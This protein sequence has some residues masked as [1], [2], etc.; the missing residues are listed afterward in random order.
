M[1]KATILLML[2]G[3]FVTGQSQLYA[4]SSGTVR[5]TVTEASSGEALIG[6]NITVLG[7]TRGTVSDVDGRYSISLAPGSYTLRASFVSYTSQTLTV[8]VTA[9]QTTDLNFQLESDIIGSDELI[10]LGTRS[11]Q[12]TVI[13]SAVPVDVITNLEIEQFAFPQTT[14]IIR[15]L[16]PSFN[17][18]KSSVTDG[19]DHI[20][21][22]TLRGLGPDQVLVLVNGKR[23]HTSSLVHVNGSIGRGSTGVDLNAIPSNM[24]ERIEVLRDGAAAQY[25]S[26]AIAGVINI[27]L[28]KTAGLDASLTLGQN[29]SVENRGYEKEESLAPGTNPQSWAGNSQFLE[30][31]VLYTDGQTM[32]F[33]LGYGGEL[34]DRGSY[35]ISGQY[36]NQEPNNR[37]GNDPRQQYPLVNGSPDPREATFNRVNHK[38]GSAELQDLSLFLNA[39]YQMD[40]QKS[41]YA[42]GGVSNR[43]G[44][45]SGFYRRALDARNTLAIYPDGFLPHIETNIFD[46]SLSTG[47]KGQLGDWDYDVSQTLG[48]NRLEYGVNKSL[49]AS[50]GETSPSKFYAGALQFSQ[51]S[52]NL[53]MVRGVDVGTA[54]PLSVAFG[55]E[56]RYEN[57]EIEAGEAPSYMAGPI[58]GKAAGSQVFPGFQPR[59]A[60]DKSRTNI[61]L[62]LDLENDITDKFLLG[63]AVRYENYSDFGSVLTAKAST[64]FE[65]TEE[66]AVRGAVSTGFRAPSLAQSYF[67]T[68][69]TNFIDGV[70]FEVGTFPVTSPVARAL[71]A[72]DLVEESSVNLSAGATYSKGNFSLTADVY[73]IELKDRVVLSENFTGSGSAGSIRDFLQGRGVNATGGRYFT[74]AVD[75]KTQG[76]DIIARYAFETENDATIRAT[77]AANFTKTE[78]TNKDEIVTPA[79]LSQY[80]SVPLFGRNEQG[81][82]EMGQPKSSVQTTFGYSK[83][84][85]N[86]TLRVNR[87]GEYTNLSASNPDFDQEYAGKLITD[88]EVGFRLSQGYRF[89]IG[90]NNLFDVYPDRQFQNSSN[91][92]IFQFPSSSPFGFAGRYIYTRINI[93][94]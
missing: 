57:Y 62:Y 91:N 38:H 79:A 55:A 6:A 8:T 34:G 73:N 4:Q 9:G 64:R 82:Y 37:G 60:T 22:A 88:L 19:T 45:A 13:E 35:Y 10:V 68:I 67:S 72:K 56:F 59:N 30:K 74:N 54:S 76:I 71:G 78:I 24:I 20:N 66:F 50:F 31:D 94:L 70:P 36:R 85:T 49:N 51:M 41:W 29:L 1:K 33:H 40:D 65:L 26:D 47:V 90:S 61:G 87:F 81:R 43:Q 18:P 46:G 3:L 69:S 83:G 2:I 15:Q 12:R 28:K 23:R 17:S 42:F 5:G 21:P 84:I 16:V 53:D 75:S 25:G 44:S 92:G 89:A 27:V 86:V 7:T 63:G 80:T 58:A 32:T 48:R 93:D 39:D 52:T 11:T 14:E 77:V